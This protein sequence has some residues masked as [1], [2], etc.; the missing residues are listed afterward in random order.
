MWTS[1]SSKLLYIYGS[2]MSMAA[3]MHATFIPGILNCFLGLDAVNCDPFITC[4]FTGQDQEN[5]KQWHLEI[6]GKLYPDLAYIK[7]LAEF[8]GTLL[9]GSLFI[10]STFFFEKYIFLKDQGTST[11]WPMKRATCHY[12]LM[13]ERIL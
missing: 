7:L 8:L 3:W 13:H 2:A 10:F 5:I 1:F 4:S 11:Y 12:L 6:G 9:L